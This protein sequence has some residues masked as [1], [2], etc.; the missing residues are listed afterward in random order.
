MHER[1]NRPVRP[2]GPTP[3]DMQDQQAGTGRDPWDPVT[4]ESQ[5]AGR[6]EPDRRD[7]EPEDVPET[8]EAG[9]GR[10]GGRP[11]PGSPNP[12]HPVPEEPSG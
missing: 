1:A 12:D 10:R 7:E 8:D 11:H 9:S 6:E 2:E 5:E 4:E 3:K